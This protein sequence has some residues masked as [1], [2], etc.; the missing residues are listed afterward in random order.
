[1]FLIL[2]PGSLSPGTHLCPTLLLP[3]LQRGGHMKKQTCFQKYS[4]VVHIMPVYIFFFQNQIIGSSVHA[5]E[6]RQYCRLA[7]SATMLCI[8]LHLLKCT[9]NRN[10]E[11]WQNSHISFLSQRVRATVVRH[12]METIGIL[13]QTEI[14]NQSNP[15]LLSNYKD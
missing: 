11:N 10:T 14:I 5:R 2:Y 3:D 9:R 8:I 7:I 6:D 4:E 13:F 1:M 15:E 12:Q